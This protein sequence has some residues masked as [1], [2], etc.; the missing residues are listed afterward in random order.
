MLA[1]DE[2]QMMPYYST[3]VPARMVDLE[4][5]GFCFKPLTGH[6]RAGRGAETNGLLLS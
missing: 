4:A 2:R 3:V 5:V 1:L 6:L